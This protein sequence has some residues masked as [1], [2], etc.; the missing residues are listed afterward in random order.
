MAEPLFD[1]RARALRR[2]RAVRREPAPFLAARIVDELGERLQPVRLRF[3]SALVTGCPP[4]LQPRLSHIAEAVT[5][6]ETFDALAEQ[7]EESID[8]LLVVGELDSRDELPLLLQIARSRMS[9][10]GLMLGA[11]PGGNGLPAL[12]EALH[13]ADRASGSFAARMHPRIEPGA[14]AG[15]LS[16][17]GFREPV[18]DVDRVRLRYGSLAGLIA[19]LR[20]HAATNMLRA[21]SGRSI[22]RAGA[23]V[24]EESFAARGS[25]GRTEE[26]VELLFFAGWADADKDRP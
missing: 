20:D 21:R 13:A 24:A 12:R 9:S 18:V 26:L 15:L 3:R 7:E 5:F 19:D 16:A 10:N 23:R 1:D 14:F 25:G 4:A 11:I 2:A 8:L 6:A 17:A 22:G